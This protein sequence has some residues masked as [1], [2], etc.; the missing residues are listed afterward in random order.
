MGWYE[1]VAGHRHGHLLQ[2]EE[3]AQ[4]KVKFGWSSQLVTLTEEGRV[5]AGA[6]VLH[7]SLLHRAL[8]LPGVTYLAKGPVV[9]WQSPDQIFRVLALVEQS[10]RRHHSILVRIEPALLE[11]EVP[12]LTEVLA[13]AGYRPARRGVQPRRTLALDIRGTEAD[14][15]GRMRPKT[16]YNIRLAERKGVA[17]RQA[18]REDLPVFSEMMATTGRRDQFGVHSPAYYEAAFDLFS[19]R[20]MVALLVAEFEGRPLAGLMV[21][22]LGANAWY[23]YGASSDAERNRMP[24]YLLQWEAIRWARSRGCVQYDLWGVPDQEAAV[25]EAEFEHRSDGLWGV[26]RFKRGFGGQLVRSVGAYDRALCRP[27]A[28]LVARLGV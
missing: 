10:A 19:A 6:V 25:L 28:W 20:G 7:R 24:A 18:G 12:T 13:Q 4:L 23:L 11:G 14:I 22:A 21:F 8:P 17:V 3:W 15:L 5:T 9:D 16:R 27:I 1:L 2:T 26:Y